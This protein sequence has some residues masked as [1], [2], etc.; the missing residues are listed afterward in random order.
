MKYFFTTYKFRCI[1]AA[2]CLLLL[3]PVNLG[4]HSLYTSW[5]QFATKYSYLEDPRYQEKERVDITGNGYADLQ[6]WDAEYISTWTYF[7]TDQTNLS[8]PLRT[9]TLPDGT[10]F[11]IQLNAEEIEGIESFMV[12]DISEF[13]IRTSWT[14]FD[15]SWMMA[16]TDLVTG[17]MNPSDPLLRQYTTRGN[18]QPKHLANV[19]NMLAESG[20]DQFILHNDIVL[21][22][23]LRRVI[24]INREDVDQALADIAAGKIN[25]LQVETNWSVK[26]QAIWMRHLDEDNSA[27]RSIIKLMSLTH[28]DNYHDFMLSILDWIVDLQII[29]N[30]ILIMTAFIIVYTIYLQERKRRTKQ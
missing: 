1:T 19:Q 20:E 25:E 5:P 21:P 26:S 3:L 6:V 23:G 18:L 15:G 30:V 12:N 29:G 4:L 14:R 27:E 16:N 28:Q 8:Q 9:V 17:Q 10:E 7:F 22:D 13:G 2:I 24:R 11:E